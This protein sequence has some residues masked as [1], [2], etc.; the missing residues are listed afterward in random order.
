MSEFSQMMAQLIASNRP[1]FNTNQSSPT[2][3]RGTD[4]MGMYG[5]KSEMKAYATIPTKRQVDDFK[6]MIKGE[7]TYEQDVAQ[8]KVLHQIFNRFA[9]ERP[10]DVTN[11]YSMPDFQKKLRRLSNV[12]NTI[13]QDPLDGLFKYMHTTPSKEEM[14]ESAH[15]YELYSKQ[16]GGQP[17]P[18][19]IQLP[20]RSMDVAPAGEG[21]VY[22]GPQYGQ[23]SEADSPYGS[24]NKGG[25]AV[26]TT[27]ATMVQ[28]PAPVA[29]P[30]NDVRMPD[31]RGVTINPMAAKRLVYGSGS[32]ADY[33]SGVYGDQARENYIGA[34][35]K[36]AEAQ[37]PSKSRLENT[38]ADMLPKDMGLK[39]REVAAREKEVNAMAA[40]HE[41]LAK[42]TAAD[43]N[44]MAPENKAGLINELGSFDRAYQAFVSKWSNIRAVGDV[45]AQQ[46]SEL[47]GLTKQVI[48]SSKAFAKTAEYARGPMLRWFG[49]VGGE[50]EKDLPENW[51]GNSNDAT[52]KEINRRRNYINQGVEMIKEAGASDPGMIK[53]LVEWNRRVMYVNDQM[54]PPNK[55]FKKAFESK[56][57]KTIAKYIDQYDKVL[58]KKLGFDMND[59]KVAAAVMNFING[60]R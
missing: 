12:D 43:A 17:L 59:P 5:K 44:D 25:G 45:A 58:L 50:F 13:Y 38:Q 21:E 8:S 1:Q 47:G 16:P 37:P 34:S 23:M 18:E 55:E 3:V 27:G 35:V 41:A 2:Q 14:I 56:D 46:I 29:I 20:Q 36:T 40:Y 11:F 6:R 7:P 32:G 22:N 57:V 9:L 24:P 42:K 51:F 31:N 53:S 15:A 52:Q 10:D 49:R 28:A 48:S 26:A 60:G 19:G 33:A 54:N 30:P 4:D 39:E